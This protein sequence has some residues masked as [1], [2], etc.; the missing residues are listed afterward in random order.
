MKAVR[1]HQPGGADQLRHEDV[2]V[3]SPGPGEALVRVRV[4]GVNFIDVYQRTGFYPVATPFVPGQEGS[5]VVESVAAGVTVVKPGD[6]VAWAGPMGSYAEL[7]AI[8]AERLVPV[9]ADLDDERAG[10]AILQGM[11]A[12]Y[13]ATE[14][15]PLRAGDWC[16][17]HAAAGGVGLLLCQ[18]ARRLGATVIATVSTDA[19]AAL[20]QAA[21]AHHVV[22]YLTEDV[23]A[24]VRRLTGGRG[25][26]VV[27][28]SVGKATWEK[29]L[30]SLQSRGMLVLSGQSSGAVPP[31][32]PLRLSRQGSL[33][34]TRPTLAH[35]TATR[36]D[37]LRHAGTV[38]GWVRDGSL[39]VRI[40]ARYPLADAARAHADLESRGTAGKL[41]LN[42]S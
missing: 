38:L 9:P 30:D 27:Y 18:I 23:A 17:V 3:P 13:L 1:V 41:L 14:A 22:R 25:V 39:K 12:H 19:K 40:H 16:L 24:E 5:G 20:A 6:R 29:S 7:V 11:T 10:A 32:D 26:R 2:P 33:F 42:V 15:G 8:A 34:L 21:G 31:I 37:L 36:E 28:D 4:A 35:Y